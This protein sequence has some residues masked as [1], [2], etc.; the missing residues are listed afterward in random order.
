[1]YICIFLHWDGSIDIQWLPYFDL[2]SFSAYIAW[3]ACLSMR[4]PFVRI[5][6]FPADTHSQFESLMIPV[7]PAPKTYQKTIWVC[8]NKITPHREYIRS[9][10][11]IIE[12]QR[13][14]LQRQGKEP[15]IQNNLSVGSC[16]KKEN[17]TKIVTPRV[18]YVK[19]RR[20]CA[21]NSACSL[22]V[23]NLQTCWVAWRLENNVTIP[24]YKHQMRNSTENVR[25]PWLSDYIIHFQETLPR[26]STHMNRNLQYHY[27]Y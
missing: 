6:L 8:A 13:H 21:T 9:G 3:D 19:Y 16:H 7:Q 22:S 24:K 11:A 23:P 18:V 12:Y 17:L 2:L 4:A 1:M 15:K 5:I 10:I 26:L 14:C 20:V 25:S 27:T